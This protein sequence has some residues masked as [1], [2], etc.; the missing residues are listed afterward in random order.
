M[1]SPW[2]ASCE[3]PVSPRRSFA[4]CFDILL[5]NVFAHRAEARARQLHQCADPAGARVYAYFGKDDLNRGM[6]E[7]NRGSGHP[8]RVSYQASR[9]VCDLEFGKAETKHGR[10]VL[11]RGQG[12]LNHVTGELS[13]RV[14]VAASSVAAV[15]SKPR[16]PSTCLF[17]SSPRT[18]EHRNCHGPQAVDAARSGALSVASFRRSPQCFD[19]RVYL[20]VG[21]THL[22]EQLPVFL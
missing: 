18:I 2:A 8:S 6:G 1:P 21:L 4:D 19:R 13:I 5:A 11:N 22:L 7:A 16:I 9:G 3:T 14:P 15:I 20:G 10:G 12:E 17:I